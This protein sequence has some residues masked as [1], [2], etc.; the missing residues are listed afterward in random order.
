MR[1]FSIMLINLLT[2]IIIAPGVFAEGGSSDPNQHF[3]NGNSWYAKGEYQKAVESYLS[4]IDRGF[5]NGELYYNIGNGFFKLGKY[6]YAVLSYEKAKKFIPG[7]SDLKSNLEY[8]RSFLETPQYDRAENPALRLMA[9]SVSSLSMLTMLT[10]GIYLGLCIMIMLY[11]FNPVFAKKFRIVVILFV[12]IFTYTMTVFLYRY[13]NEEILK[14]GIVV[15]KEA[16]C[17]YEPIDKSMT[18]FTVKEGEDVVIL[19]TKDGWQ[20]LRRMDGKSGWVDKESVQ[21]I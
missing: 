7:D 13:Y 1:R 21:E 9:A 5:E 10:L 8:T 18:Y 17:K 12:V 3:Y 6:G 16:E 15:V 14:R 11:I 19:D 4:L 20:E 2:F